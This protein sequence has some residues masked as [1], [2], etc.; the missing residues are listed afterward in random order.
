MKS[1]NDHKVLI[2]EFFSF[3][4]FL[5]FLIINCSMVHLVNKLVFQ[6]Y[7]DSDTIIK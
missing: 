6:T 5:A 4:P 1:K 3:I 7:Q 2:K